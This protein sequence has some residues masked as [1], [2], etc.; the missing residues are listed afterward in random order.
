MEHR[1]P[2]A[3]DHL[4]TMSTDKNL[5]SE[6][7]RR[8][9]AVSALSVAAH[10]AIVYV[11]VYFAAWR[12]PG[13]WIVP[14]W[15][16]FGILGHGFHQL[17][18]ECAHKLT[19]RTAWANDALAHW[20][21]A[22]LYLADFDAFRARHFMHH[23]SLGG[24]GDPKY[25][26]R[27]DIRGLR[28][29]GLVTSMLTL[30]G[31]IRKAL[32]QV[33]SN[34]GASSE[35]TRAAALRVVIVQPIFCLSILLVARAGHPEDWNAALLAAALAYFFVYL[36]GV[37]ALTVMV[38]TLRGIAEHRA[39][40][41][42]PALEGTAALRNFKHARLDW[43]VFGTYG[44]TDHATHH[45]Y[46][47]LPSYRLPEVSAVLAANEPEM[48]PV[49]THIAIIARLIKAKTPSISVLPSVEG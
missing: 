9:D 1:P 43:L 28:F 42:D 10:F 7:E 34:S 16:W 17:L 41:A 31:A 37:A 32:L 49:G 13:W 48:K 4:A 24:D 44:F 12:G 21:V 2:A 36:Y 8:S 27:I 6:T 22:P 33:G 23:R 20:L 45:R 40:E 19:F 30:S 25:T 35:S 14:C 46:P 18:H 29:L 15:L 39:S 3:H 38:A 11:A 26:Y 47:A 5:G